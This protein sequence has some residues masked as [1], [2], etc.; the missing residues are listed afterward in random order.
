MIQGS[1]KLK[2]YSLKWLFKPL[3]LTKFDS[4]WIRV[5]ATVVFSRIPG[6]NFTNF[7]EFSSRQNFLNDSVTNFSPPPLHN[8]SPLFIVLFWSPRGTI[9]SPVF[10]PRYQSLCCAHRPEGSVSLFFI[11]SFLLV[12]FLWKS[13][14]DYLFRSMLRS[15]SSWSSFWPSFFF[16]FFL[17]WAESY[18]TGLKVFRCYSPFLY[19]FILVPRGATRLRYEKSLQVFLLFFLLGHLILEK[20][21][22]IL[23]FLCSFLILFLLSYLNP[24]LTIFTRLGDPEPFGNLRG[25][26]L[27]FLLQSSD[28]GFFSFS[29]FFSH[30]LLGLPFFLL[31]VFW[32]ASLLG[33]PFLLF[34]F[35]WPLVLISLGLSAVTFW[36]S[37][38][39]I[40]ERG[41]SNWKWRDLD[42][43]CTYR[44]NMR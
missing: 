7:S 11:L 22:S 14:A 16:I 12:L 20:D 21:V 8:P 33:L 30:K 3:R 23:C 38:R 37:T 29:F 39:V 44:R 32:A 24:V 41:S 19:F 6:S 34:F 27:S 42:T 17:K 26:R 31:D 36:T 18:S 10:P 40:P 35:P 9:D 1:S 5:C 13:M 15:R 43:L 2:N 4:F 25:S 28:L